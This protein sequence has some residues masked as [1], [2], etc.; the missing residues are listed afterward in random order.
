[1]Q[2]QFTA[3]ETA[4][5]NFPCDR[6][7]KVIIAGKRRVYVTS[8]NPHVLGKHV[9]AACESHYKQKLATTATST[10]VNQWLCLA[11]ERCLGTAP[12]D[13]DLFTIQRPQESVLGS[14]APRHTYVDVT[15]I[16][17]GISEGNRQGTLPSASTLAKLLKYCF[18]L[19]YCAFPPNSCWF[20]STSFLQY[21][22]SGLYNGA[23]S[24]E[25]SWLIPYCS[26]C[27]AGHS[28]SVLSDGTTP[29]STANDSCTSSC[30]WLQLEPPVIC[31]R[32]STTSQTSL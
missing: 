7:N 18:R 1:M 12:I 32:A 15:G 2:T 14:Q 17:Q 30:H 4:T 13:R 19:T 22:R 24:T 21:C 6:C 11:S 25:S 10:L 3:D 5:E 20:I 27:S 31:W 9:C 23:A 26:G 16:H 8:V 29:V 28:L